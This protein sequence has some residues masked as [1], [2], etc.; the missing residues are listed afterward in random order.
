[1]SDP[2]GAAWRPSS[3][4]ISSI[5]LFVVGNSP[6]VRTVSAPSAPI[7]IAAHPP[8]AASVP[9]PEQAPSVTRVKV[10]VMGSLLP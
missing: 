4:A 10:S 5:R 2:S 7:R 9:L 8:R 6:P 3:A 1:M